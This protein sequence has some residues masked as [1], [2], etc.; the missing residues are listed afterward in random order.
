MH[1]L[2]KKPFVLNVVNI[3]C[4]MLYKHA[5]FLGKQFRKDDRKVVLQTF[6]PSKCKSIYPA[7][8]INNK[9]R[10]GC[11][12][13]I[14]VGRSDSNLCNQC[15][16][17]SF[18]LFGHIFVSTSVLE[19]N[20]IQTLAKAQ[21]IVRRGQKTRMDARI[22]SKKGQETGNESVK[23]RLLFLQYSSSMIYFH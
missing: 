23:G 22:K 18:P 6:K 8:A 7:F 15:E 11:R 13:I 10:V 21:N 17:S 2:E 16:T 19:T 5:I 1:S 14:F 12:T 9:S 4:L 3:T 20:P